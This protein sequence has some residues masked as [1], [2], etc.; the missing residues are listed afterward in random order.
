VKPFVM[1]RK[2]WLF[3]SSMDG[4]YASSVMYS[5][6]ET[7][8]LNGLNPFQYLSFLLESLTNTSTDGL[9]RLLPWSHSLPE[10]CRVPV[11]T[12]LPPASLS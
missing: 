1:G 9:E 8:K 5:I 10:F 6:I 2:N 7:A 4:A 12:A 11:K 3:A